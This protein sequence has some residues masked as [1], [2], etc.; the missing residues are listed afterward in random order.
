M[1]F[2][3]DSVEELKNR[4]YDYWALGHI[5]K[6]EIIHRQS[7]AIIY[8]GN[9][10][11]RHTKESG[12][13]GCYLIE[14]DDKNISYTFKALSKVLFLDEEVDIS[15]QN[16]ME[17]LKEV[18]KRQIKQQSKPS[19]LKLTL[20]GESQLSS[21]IESKHTE[22]IKLFLADLHVNLL[23]LINRT[24]YPKTVEEI[25]EQKDAIGQLMAELDKDSVKEAIET[26]KNAI[27]KEVLDFIGD[28][29]NQKITVEDE[30]IEKT[31]FS[32]LQKEL[33]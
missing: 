12:E 26:E 2:D 21:V 27:K 32:Q 1:C 23:K 24:S 33:S 5:H 25:Q 15:G 14:I 31:I 28:E 4:G 13:K 29:L 30:P 6:S 17:G 19:Y 8:S 16:S 11:G 20:T 10:Q 22:S 3:L 18:I 9:L 7:P